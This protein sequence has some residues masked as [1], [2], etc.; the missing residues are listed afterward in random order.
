LKRAGALLVA[1]PDGAV[2]MRAAPRARSAAMLRRDR[3]SRA[4]SLFRMLVLCAAAASLGACSAGGAQ[5]AGRA[6]PLVKAEPATTMHFV[7]SIEAIGTALANEQVTVSSPVTER[8]VRLNFDDGDFVQ[9]GQTLAVLAAAQENAQLAQ[10]QARSV[11]AQQQLGR[12]KELRD[13]GFATKSSLD[14]QMAAA[15]EARAQSA[16]ARATIGDRI[17]SAPFSGWVS[18]RN[19]SPGAIVQ[20]G[21]EIATV[22][23]LS[24]IKL[25]FTVP[26]TILPVLKPGLPIKAVSAAYPGQPFIGRINVIDPVLDPTTRAVKVRALLPNPDLKLKPGMLLTVAI[27]S[28]ARDAVSV[29]ELAVV[30]E[31]DLRYVFALAAGN[32]IKRMAVR[33]GIRM[34]GRIEIIEGLKPGQKVVA[35][36]V[37]KVSD[38]MKVRLAGPANAQPPARPQKKAG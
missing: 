36:G 38:G 4:A 25:D 17:V 5:K 15:A 28:Q 34:N 16:Q 20:A 6:P 11:E 35:E 1:L 37:G 8:I 9:R 7:D 21:T 30:G 23:D 29:P 31:G 26:E 2:R 19:I 27:Q 22:S 32:T 10:A 3:C 14:Q 12:V 24:T 13:R 33:T 18:L